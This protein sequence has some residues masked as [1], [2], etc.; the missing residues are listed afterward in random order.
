MIVTEQ[1]YLLLQNYHGLRN[2]FHISVISNISYVCEVIFLSITNATHYVRVP[3]F[4]QL[5]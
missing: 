3:N 5:T 2:S 4:Q 1:Q